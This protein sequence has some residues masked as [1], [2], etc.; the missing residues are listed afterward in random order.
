MDDGKS[1]KLSLDYGQYVATVSQVE[2][3]TTSNF[4]IG[5]LPLLRNGKD[6]NSTFKGCIHSLHIND[7]VLPISSTTPNNITLVSS[8]PG[9]PIW[10]LVTPT[11]HNVLKGCLSTAVCATRPCPTSGVCYDEWEQHRYILAM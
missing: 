8:L 6:L 9:Q 5:A 1:T 7:N 3:Q 11:P 10:S 4:L 2:S